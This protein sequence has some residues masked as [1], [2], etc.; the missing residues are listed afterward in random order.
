MKKA[1]DHKGTNRCLVWTSKVLYMACM[2]PLLEMH[3]LA[4]STVP[5]ILYWSL[6]RCAVILAGC[7]LPTH[8]LFKESCQE[9][10]QWFL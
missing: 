4:C 8:G 9:C 5:E 2:R 10:L 3:L 6:A 7:L 1:N